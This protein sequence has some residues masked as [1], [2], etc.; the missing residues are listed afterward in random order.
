PTPPPEVNLTPEQ[1]LV[2]QALREEEQ[3]FDALIRATGITAARMN[4]LLL[5]LEMRR[6]IRLLPGRLVTLVQ[7]D[8]AARP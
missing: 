8:G 1:R 2:L 4:V 6:Q 3:D 7:R 5:E